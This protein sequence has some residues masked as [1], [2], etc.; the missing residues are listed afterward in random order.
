MGKAALQQEVQWG[1]NVPYCCYNHQS[2]VEPGNP[3]KWK[4][5]KNG[6]KTVLMLC[7]FPSSLHDPLK[8][9]HRF[10]GKKN[11]VKTADVRSYW[12]CVCPLYEP[13]S[14]IALLSY[15]YQIILF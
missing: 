5:S 7:T 15:T 12:V 13:K 14:G 2:R 1:W 6:V 9:L 8:M 3:E 10:L 11:V 4:V